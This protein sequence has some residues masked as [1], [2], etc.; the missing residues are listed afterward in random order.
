MMEDDLCLSDIRGRSDLVFRDA[1][2]GCCS[3]SDELDAMDEQLENTGESVGRGSC[4]RYVV[5]M[6]EGCG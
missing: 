6:V 5:V 1:A 2:L 4:M 3:D